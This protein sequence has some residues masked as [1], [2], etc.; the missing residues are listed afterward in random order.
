[1]DKEG[2]I[3]EIVLKELLKDIEFINVDDQ[4]KI[5]LDQNTVIFGANGI[6]K[7]TIYHELKKKYGEFEYLDYEETKDAF[8]ASDFKLYKKTQSTQL[9][10]VLGATT[11]VQI[12]YRSVIA[13]H[14]TLF[15]D[16][17]IMLKYNVNRGRVWS[18]GASINSIGTNHSIIQIVEAPNKL[19]SL[20]EELW[21]QTNC[22]E[23]LI[24]KR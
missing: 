18:L 1:M 15:H 16:R 24:Y 14:G 9:A 2:I 5:N 11:D 7:T 8:N 3:V 22:E 12:E 21:N 19:F 23:C 13:Q 6:G 17:Y 20:F 10:R 4:V